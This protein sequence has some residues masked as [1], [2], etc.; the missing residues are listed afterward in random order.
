MTNN[1]ETIILLA[2][3]DRALLRVAR[4]TVGGCSVS[5]LS[6]GSPTDHGRRIHVHLQTATDQHRL[7]P[8]RHQY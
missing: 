1:S 4:V 2:I 7:L 5:R 8:H 6:F 3:D